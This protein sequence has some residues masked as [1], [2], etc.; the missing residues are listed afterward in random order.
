MHSFYRCYFFLDLK[1]LNKKKRSDIIF[2]LRKVN[3]EC[4][5]GSCPEIYLE[6]A[7]KIKNMKFI[8]LKNAKELGKI[9]V[10]LIINHRFSNIKQIE[11][12]NSLQKILNKFI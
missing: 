12:L 2:H 8:R 7:F 5:V 6:K 9:S 4:N 10:A 3:I 1:K 11:Y